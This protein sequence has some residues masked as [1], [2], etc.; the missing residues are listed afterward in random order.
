ML[1]AAPALGSGR[2]IA[3]RQA[4]TAAMIEKVNHARGRHGL[5]PLRSSGSLAGSSRRFAAHLMKT[6]LLAHRARPSTSYPLAGEVLAMHRGR[7]ARVGAT[8]S[9]WMRSPAHRAVLLNPLM[10]DMGAGLAHGRF[11]RARAVIWVVQV[12][13]R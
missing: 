8:V 3:K 4:V 5:R 11:G 7:R 1:A 6:N 2:Y 12:G 9:S 13:K 10:Q